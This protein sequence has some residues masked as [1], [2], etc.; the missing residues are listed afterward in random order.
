MDRH[1]RVF[2]D[3][4]AKVVR[5]DCR[6]C[7]IRVGIARFVPLE[8]EAR[9]EIPRRAPVER[10]HVAGNLSLAEFARGLGGLLGRL[11]PGARDP[12]AK[13]PPGNVRR[14][15]GELRVGV[16]DRRR[17][18]RGED[19]EIER[20]VVDQYRVRAVRPVRIADTVGDHA[21]RVHEHA[22]C[23][24][25]VAGTPG[26]RN[27]LV[28]MPCVDA[29]RVDDLRM[30]DLAALVERAEFLAEPVHRRARGQRHR[31]GPLVALAHA[32]ERRQPGEA[33]KVLV[34]RRAQHLRTAM[35]QPESQRRTGD[36]E[37]G[38]A[39]RERDRAV[40]GLRDVAALRLAE[41][42]PVIGSGI[43]T[44]AQPEHA[45]TE[46]GDLQH[47]ARRRRERGAR[48]GRADAL[49]R[50]ESEESG[51]FELHATS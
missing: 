47:V 48:S 22:P 46:A 17:R 5:L 34:G 28:R 16:E 14:A 20:L 27:V 1:V 37:H 21:G 30:D 40:V 49:G 44:H 19:E 31:D 18:V 7:P 23:A 4:D 9:L 11:V 3:A 25:A 36:L 2:P 15:A 50:V 24:V 42:E 32:P 8:V 29:E 35:L 33:A 26:E 43:G 12:Q 51:R 38:I 13:A 41:D 45:G 6:E 10:Q 39:R